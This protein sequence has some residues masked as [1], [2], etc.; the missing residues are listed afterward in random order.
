MI[1]LF[2][3]SLVWAF[4][5]G[6]IK[7]N[8]SGLDSSFVSFCRMAISLL[9]F[10]PFLRLRGLRPLVGVKLAATGAVQFGLMYVTYIHAF[11]FLPAHHVA[12]CTILTPIYVTLINDALA[13][14]FRAGRVAAALLS[15]AGAWVIVRG[16]T[17]DVALR[18]GFFLLQASNLCF[19]SGQVFYR[20]IM[21]SEPAL[22]DDRVF[23]LLY[24]GA[25]AV[26]AACA[27]FTVDL[28]GIGV[29]ARQAWTLL[30]LGVLA[31]GVC[32]F[33][34]NLGAK[35][36]KAGMLAVM[37]NLKIPLAV[38]CSLLFFGEE[39]EVPALLAGGG[40]IAA[41][42]LLDGYFARRNAIPGP[43]EARKE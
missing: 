32:F 26:T 36:T 25:F 21:R 2:T 33:L 28:S 37:N 39:A 1:Y 17:G 40:I 10:L 12:I 31:S 43:S 41:A 30:Y 9:V 22:R 20:R 23:A 6:L 27:A 34:W 7:G 18:T 16:D 4:S 15:V 35:R 11:R 19:A 38:A 5:F 3:V 8:L 13:R 24:L 42:L 14:R 29:T